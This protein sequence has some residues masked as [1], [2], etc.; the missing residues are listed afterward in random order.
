MLQQDG[1][2]VS[3]QVQSVLSAAPQP[4]PPWIIYRE[5]RL[6]IAHLHFQSMEA[7]SSSRRVHSTDCRRVAVT[8]HALQTQEQPL[9]RLHA[10]L[11]RV[12]QSMSEN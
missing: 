9:G 1:T 6:Y 2:G 7:Q 8:E 12:R 3:H 5:L 10:T 11:Q 4:R